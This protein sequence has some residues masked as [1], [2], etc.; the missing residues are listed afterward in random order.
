M[1]VCESHTASV[2]PAMEAAR[3]AAAREAAAREAAAREA[4][5]KAGTI[6]GRTARPREGS[7]IPGVQE[8]TRGTVGEEIHGHAL[9]GREAKT[10]KD[11]GIN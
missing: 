9:D 2:A 7:G 10:E 6:G 8:E 4:A 3:T 5:A 1:A 11:T